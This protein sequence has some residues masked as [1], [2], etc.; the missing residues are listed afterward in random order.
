MSGVGKAAAAQGALILQD[1]IV[2]NVDEPVNENA[3]FITF[4]RE[5]IVETEA[6]ASKKCLRSSL[7]FS[8]AA[9]STSF[10]QA[11]NKAN[12]ALPWVS[13]NGNGNGNAEKNV[14]EGTKAKV[15]VARLCKHPKVSSRYG[16]MAPV[17]IFIVF[18]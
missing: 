11:D 13:C 4:L 3:C 8:S 15:T 14:E 6:E 5:D 17:F 12:G 18:Y 2:A 9:T 10:W 16:H 1:K 7:S